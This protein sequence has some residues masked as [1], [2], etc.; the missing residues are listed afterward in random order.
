MHYVRSH[1]FQLACDNGV[2]G[3]ISAQITNNN[4]KKFI[5]WVSKK[6]TCNNLVLFNQ[7]TILFCSIN[8][9]KLKVYFGSR[10]TS[11]WILKYIQ[12]QISNLRINF[13]EKNH[14]QILKAENQKKKKNIEL[15]A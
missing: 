12:K 2:Y 8:I 10:L 5:Y 11:G 6:N 15:D 14:R 3:R 4:E 13:F 7:L 1:N 9:E